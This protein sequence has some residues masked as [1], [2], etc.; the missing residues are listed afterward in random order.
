MTGLPNLRKGV[1][2]GMATFAVTPH[3]CRLTAYGPILPVYKVPHFRHCRACRGDPKAD[4]PHPSQ[5]LAIGCLLRMGY[6][7]KQ[8]GERACYRP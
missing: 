8:A 3:R 2:S 1:G 5:R 6:D 7:A 4:G